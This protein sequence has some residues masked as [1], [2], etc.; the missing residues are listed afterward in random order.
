MIQKDKTKE[1]ATLLK[2]CE[3]LLFS[4]IRTIRLGMNHLLNH[5]FDLYSP[6]FI[7]KSCT[8]LWG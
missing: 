5:L 6:T 3:Y 1:K 7:L 2:S 4:I 8:T